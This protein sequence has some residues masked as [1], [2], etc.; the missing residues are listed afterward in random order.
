ML[1][2]ANTES[3]TLR[4]VDRHGSERIDSFHYDIY[5]DPGDLLQEARQWVHDRE[6]SGFSIYL[7]DIT[8]KAPNCVEESRS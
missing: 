7:A 3:F 8:F 6:E 1:L 5:R 4:A 2:P